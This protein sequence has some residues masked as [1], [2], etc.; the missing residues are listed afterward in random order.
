VATRAER[1]AWLNRRTDLA[2]KLAA[3]NGL[4]AESTQ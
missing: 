3:A 2:G 4:T 1:W